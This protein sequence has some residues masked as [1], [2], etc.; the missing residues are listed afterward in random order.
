[1]RRTRG[2]YKFCEHCEARHGR[3]PDKLAML[4]GKAPVICRKCRGLMGTNGHGTLPCA[5]MAEAY[6]MCSQGLLSTNRGWISPSKIPGNYPDRHYA[7]S[8]SPH[9]F[10]I[11][12]AFGQPATLAASRYTSA[13][14]RNE[15][16]T[17]REGMD[18]LL[19][20][21]N[22]AR[23]SMISTPDMARRF[24][25]NRDLFTEF[26]ALWNLDASEK[27]LEKALEPLKG[28]PTR[29]GPDL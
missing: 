24:A 15:C 5:A 22:A 21:Q 9:A 27:I 23:R 11:L 10:R 18:L 4:T 29:P 3:L 12:R 28:P 16:W 8:G 19:F 17:T 25:A 2:N 7:S 1:M 13:G 14:N 6:R 26:R 20:I